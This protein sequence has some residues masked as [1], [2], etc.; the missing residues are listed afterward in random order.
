ME[1]QPFI[2]FRN[3]NKAFGKKVIYEGLYL[4]IR[5]GESITVIGGSGTGKSVMLKMLIGLL[6]P[7][8]GE[9]WFDGTELTGLAEEDLIPIR[10]RIAMLFQG[11]A[12]FDSLT[13]YDN[14]AYPLVEH[15]K[16]DE[17]QISDRVA[18]VL[19]LVGLPGI[20]QMKPAELSG[21]MKK[22]VGLARAI[23]V[24]PEVIMY[25]EPTTGLDP[26]N[27]T[28]IN[29]LIIGM[30]KALGVTS[31]VVTHDMGS[32]FKVSDRIAMLYKMQIT[33][34]GTVEEIHNSQDP[35]VRSFVEGWSKADVAM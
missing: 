30:K 1:E 33:R 12:L 28:R 17:K 9:I 6:K 22:R 23:A 14:I 26:I 32:A 19:G 18:E 27:T 8:S 3:I 20:E 29:E 35:V 7:D 31:I 10:R 11:A 34:V 21:G 24:G 2:S 16:M 15:L 25:D 13:V 4:D 5:K